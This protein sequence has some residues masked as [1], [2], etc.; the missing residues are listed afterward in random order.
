MKSNKKQLSNAAAGCSLVLASV[1]I[2][3]SCVMIQPGAFFDSLRTIFQLPS[4]VLLNYLPVLIVLLIVYLLCGKV[5]TGAAITSLLFNG[6]S[7]AN[8]LKMDGRN[9]PLVPS[10][11]TM[12]R[13]SLD[14][15]SDYQLNL[16]PFSLAVLIGTFVVFMILSHFLHTPRPRRWLVRLS[17]SAALAAALVGM[18][19]TVYAD[20]DY[21]NKL[22]NMNIANV[23]NVFN[24]YGFN[25]CFLHNAT[26][27]TVDKPTD[28]SASE[29][30]Q[31]EQ[32]TLPADTPQNV[33]V[34]CIMGESF[35]K[36]SDESAFAYA[37]EQDNPLYAYHQLENSGQAI[38]GSIIVSGFGAGTANTEFD[39]ITGM[40]TTLLDSTNPAC[41]AFRTVHH[42]IPTLA[43]ISAAQGA[44][45]WFMHP[46]KSWFYNR[47]S[48]Y[49][50]FGIEDQTFEDVFE[51]MPL[52]GSFHTDEAFLSVMDDGIARLQQ[53][54]KYFIFSVTI[55]NHQAYTAAKYGDAL[56]EEVPF[57]G[58][59]SANSKE[60]LSVYLQGVR[61]TSEMLQELTQQ[62][63]QSDEP[64]LLLF[65]GDHRPAL[66][67]DYAAYR[68]IGSDC[69][70]TD[71]PEHILYAHEV[72]YL[73][74]GNTS[75]LQQY[76]FDEASLDLPQ[77]GL[78][79][80]NYL[81]ALVYEITGMT[82]QDAYFDFLTQAR[83]TLPVFYQNCYALPN[84]EY[85][86]TLTQ[87]QSDVL[88]KL[89]CWQ[90]YRLKSAQ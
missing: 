56:T 1:V 51:G 13:E 44:Q 73:I 27:Y 86:D 12:I 54:G 39:V 53:N 40:Q 2:W 77:N 23:P 79:N 66:G 76:P 16:H 72:P 80:S 35:S 59:L 24:T 15:V 3:L 62:L 57:D 43:S 41:S 21:Y 20:K 29:V 58:T 17:A 22:P 48:V 87:E 28:Y 70:K 42:K 11:L 8:L 25:Y 71:T 37:S 36:L 90:Y 75:Y 26:L 18:I 10:D 74:W 45:T 85:T 61:H 82:G 78:L 46:G 67:A 32:Q 47:E 38:S 33:N 64:T 19:F 6:L 83:R 65:F 88:H 52:A 84:G 14:A 9:D 5:F 89:H 55:E 68:E 81:G 69:G 4:L 63:N 50:Y 60:Q 49:R 30:K 31:W 7:Y 34:I